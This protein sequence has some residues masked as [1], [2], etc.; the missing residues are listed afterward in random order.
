LK[1]EAAALMAA[2]KGWLSHALFPLRHLG[3]RPSLPGV[4]LKKCKPGVQ[5]RRSSE[6]KQSVSQ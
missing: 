1:I 5:D 3:D 2:S 4:W 6:A